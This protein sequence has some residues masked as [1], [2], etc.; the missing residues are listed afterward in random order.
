MNYFNEPSASKRCREAGP[1]LTA[2]ASP[3]RTRRSCDGAAA[4]P[5]P[6]QRVPPPGERPRSVQLGASHRHG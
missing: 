2:S 6:G 1:A 3:P 5:Q 4:E